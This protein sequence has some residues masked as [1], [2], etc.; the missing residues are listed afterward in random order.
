MTAEEGN[1]LRNSYNSACRSRVMGLISPS[2]EQRVLLGNVSWP[3]F[4][5]LADNAENP[6]GRLA[7][8]QGVLEI[9]SPSTLHETVKKLIGRMVETFTLEGDIELRSV[10]ST[11]FKR[12]DLETGIEADECYYVQGAAAVRDVEEIDLS[13]HPPPDL[14]IEIDI[15]RSSRIKLGIYAALQV[16]EVWRYDGEV[17]HVLHL[18]AARY[19]EGDSSAVLP[20]FPLAEANRLLGQWGALGETRLIRQFQAWLRQHVRLD[21]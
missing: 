16:P 5:A 17:I 1:A 7:Y 20:Q 8:D 4:L 3:I 15:S 14:A 19:V 10:S 21:R 9:M 2:A 13:I 12:H 18:R 11:T 6:R